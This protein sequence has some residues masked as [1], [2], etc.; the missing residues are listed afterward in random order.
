MIFCE[1]VEIKNFICSTLVVAVSWTS[2]RDWSVWIK[3]MWTTSA[4]AREQLRKEFNLTHK[5]AWC[6]VYLLCWTPTFQNSI[7]YRSAIDWLTNK[8][9]FSL[10]GKNLSWASLIAALFF[11]HSYRPRHWF[12]LIS[13]F[14]FASLRGFF[15]SSISFGYEASRLPSSL[16][17]LKKSWFFW[18]FFVLSNLNCNCK[19]RSLFLVTV[20]SRYRFLFRILLNVLREY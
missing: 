16:R 11:C 20:M 8:T 4:L 2:G 15:K 9:S 3:S 10:L 14:T 19:E 12:K 17:L 18:Q 5:F 1:T 13:T 6:H 7:L